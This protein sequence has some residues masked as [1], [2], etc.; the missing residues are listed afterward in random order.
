MNKLLSLLFI[1]V[2]CSS[3]LHAQVDPKAKAILDGVSARVKAMKS[4]KANFVLALSK[5]KQTKSGVMYMKGGKYFVNMPGQ[6]I[7]CDSRTI[8]TYTKAG[9][10]LTIN[11]MDPNENTLTPTKLFSNFYDKEF[12]SKYI[13]EKKAG[14][15]VVHE[16]EL[17]PTKPKNFTKV[18]LQ[19]N[20]ATNFISSGKV[21][22]K[23]GNIMSYTISSMTSNATMPDAQFVFDAKKHPGVEVVDLR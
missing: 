23:N 11:D 18:I 7:Y 4:L 20:K 16:I 13:G 22:E 19:I 15:L 10:E 6:E 12:K 21:F 9:N 5:T 2:L 8:S 3:N 17:T 1:A 14:T